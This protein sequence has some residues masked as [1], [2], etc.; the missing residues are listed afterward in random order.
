MADC[1]MSLPSMFSV[2][3]ELF[4]GDTRFLYVTVDVLHTGQNFNKSY[5]D[6]GVVDSCVES[7]KNTPILGFI[8]RDR[9]SGSDDFAGHEYVIK[10]TKDGIEEAYMGRCFGVVPESCN[11]R[12]VTKICDDGEEREFLQVDAIMWEKFSDATSILHRD[13]EKA[14]SMELEIASVEGE[15]DDTGIYHYT[16][17]RFDGLCILGDDVRPAMANANIKINEGV[18]FSMSDFKEVVQKELNDKIELFNRAFAKLT[19]GCD[20]DGRGGVDNMTDE[21]TDFSQTVLQHFDDV[22]NIVANY[23]MRKDCW[24]ED[25]PRYYLVDIQDDEAIVVDACDHYHYYGF[26]ISTNGDTPEVDF[27]GGGQRKKLRYENYEGVEG[28]FNGFD[29]G[30]QLEHAEDTALSKVKAVN[31]AK[32]E[33]ETAFAE[34]RANYDEIKPK[35]D[36]YVF[37]E[38]EREAEEL[39]ATKD[40]KFAEYEDVL[41]DNADFAALKEKKADLTVDEI[42]KECAVMYVKMSR[43]NKANFSRDETESVSLGVFDDDASDNSHYIHTKYGNIRRN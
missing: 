9:Y 6:K 42:E 23:E 1:K 5:F 25:A 15:T 13:S 40:S 27:A 36:E 19:E 30:V 11:P 20:D 28:E 4:E 43:A 16:K 2:N 34:V 7:I 38:A 21:K 12:W 32:A 31:A 22:S 18:N 41:G 10:K 17:F 39:S 26:T 8:R 3:N 24:G 14:Q 29:F 33:V 35:Y 37:A